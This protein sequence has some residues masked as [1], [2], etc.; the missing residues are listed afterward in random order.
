MKLFRPG[1]FQKAFIAILLLIQFLLW[2]AF[3]VF[4]AIYTVFSPWAVLIIASLFVLNVITGLYIFNSSSPDAYKLSWMIAVFALPLAVIIMYLAFANKQVRR[5]QRKALDK[6]IRPLE[7]VPSDPKTLEALN[8]VEP[9][10]VPIQKFIATAKGGG[11]FERTSVT[12][13]PLVDEA[14]PHLLEDLKKARH[15]IFIEVF[16]LEYDGYFFTNVHD[17]LLQKVKEGVDV[18]LIYDDMGS[19]KVAPS[20]YDKNLRKE[21]IK[22]YRFNRFRPVIDVRQNN[23]DHRKM[24]IIDGHT[25]Y[26]GG[27]N[28]AD[29]YIN[30][31]TRFGHWKD[32]AIRLCGEAVFSMSM[33]FLDN[34]HTSFEKDSIIDRDLYSPSKYIDEV[35]GFPLTSGF[36]QPFGDIPFD[37]QAVGQ[38]VYLQLIQRARRYI[39]IMTPYLIIDKEIENALI[40]AS[41]SGID[42]RLITPHIPDKKTVFQLT[43]SH[44]GK[45][46]LNGCKI[47]EYTPG[48]VHAKTCLIDDTMGVIGTINFDYRSLYLHLEN[49]T[50]IVASPSLLDIKKDFEDTFAKSHEL[51]YAEYNAFHEKRWLQWA[52]L[53]IIAPFL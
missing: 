48:F 53:R 2:I 14:F 33:M 22:A 40:A 25:A 7:D 35:G 13:F 17:I 10:A 37:S 38:R 27:F 29:E 8:Y 24:V 41:K 11:I 5:K 20:G 42:V 16:I 9:N 43:R 15:Y 12:Y 4:V 18:R 21:G 23:R 44:Y 26:T 32:N 3:F 6:W 36:V 30:K 50:L 49:G 46:L 39:Y 52:L 19:L 34:W 28:F 51:N 31:I 47:Y 45:L 1:F